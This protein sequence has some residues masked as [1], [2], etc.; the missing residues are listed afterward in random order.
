MP[1]ILIIDDDRNVRR[2]VRETLEAC[3]EPYELIEAITAEDGLSKLRENKPDVVLLDIFLPMTSGLDVFHHVSTFDSRLPVIFITGDTDSDTAIEAMMLGAYDYLIKP[4]DPH[5]LVRLVRRAIEM[6]RTMQTPVKIP[7]ER[8]VSAADHLVG[9]SRRMLDVYKAVGR[10][11]SQDVTVL[12][13]GESGTGKELVARAVFQHSPRKDG[14]FLAVNCAAMPDTLLESE[15]FGHEKGAF[16]GAD[17]RRIGKFEQCH[18]GTIFLDEVGDMSPITQGKILRLLQ[19]QEFERVGGNE[20]IRTDVRIIAA[21]N[22]DLEAGEYREDLF[23]RLNGFSIQIPPLRERGSD[24]V[25]LLE[26]F[27]GRMGHDLKRQHV[28]GIAPDA[29]QLLLNYSW[30]GN[31]RELQSV[32]RHALLNA[33]G[34]VIVPDCLPEEIRNQDAGAEAGES[35]T[36]ANST[37]A[38]SQLPVSDVAPFIDEAL[39]ANVQDLYALVVERMER[40]LFT[41]VLQETGGNQSKAAEILGI[42]RGKVADRIHSF[43]IQLEQEV[44]LS[45]A[46]SRQ[47]ET[48]QQREHPSLE[49]HSRENDARDHH[50]RERESREQESPEPRPT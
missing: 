12:I 47:Q 8:E 25:H 35:A 40:Y 19:Q 11:A 2:M 49:Q 10:V 4:L 38:S 22:R 31:V 29:V 16:T 45:D 39:K 36:R 33:T 41:R 24:V 1:T 5:N 15:L 27:L 13:R 32:V 44:H 7:L 3:P 34:P 23:Y 6:R 28:E 37:A 17:R 20:T 42:G 46:D 26:Y 48:D 43:G 30:P 18:R 50:A 14:P 9:R 21:T